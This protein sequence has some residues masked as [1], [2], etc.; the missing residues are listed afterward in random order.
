MS[1][2][3]EYTTQARTRHFTMTTGRDGLMWLEVWYLDDPCNDPHERLPMTRD[4]LRGL[5]GL[6]Q[7]ELARDEAHAAFVQKYE[8]AAAAEGVTVGEWM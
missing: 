3:T 2:A 7:R 4:D 5:A 6:I 1:V 8:D